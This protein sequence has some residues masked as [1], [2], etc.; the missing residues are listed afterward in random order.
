MP[1]VVWI[2][3][4]WIFLQSHQEDVF[5]FVGGVERQDAHH[6]EVRDKRGVKE[7]K[8]NMLSFMWPDYCALH[9][10]WVLMVVAVVRKL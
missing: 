1:D 5:F 10:G 8:A 4:S 7:H 2:H 3:P 6:D 9:H